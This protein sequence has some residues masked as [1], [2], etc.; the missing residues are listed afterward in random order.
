MDSNAPCLYKDSKGNRCWDPV[1]KGKGYCKKHLKPY[2]YSNWGTDLPK[3]Y[4]VKHTATLSR[5]KYICYLCGE[6][7]AN[8]VEHVIPRHL[9]GSD[10][11][12]NLKAV[13]DACQRQKTAA[14][15]N[16]AKRQRN[17]GMKRGSN[18]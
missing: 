1:F 6:G 18:R 5:D 17:T 4:R 10:N 16:E 11:M 15:A 13:H 8:A 2:E 9:G 7:A 12:H 3:N 14:E